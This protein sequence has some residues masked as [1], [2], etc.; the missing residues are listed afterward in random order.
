MNQSNYQ[1]DEMG[2]SQG[3]LMMKELRRPSEQA[4]EGRMVHSSSPDL[5]ETY[6][7]QNLKEQASNQLEPN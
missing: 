3:N 2:G 7:V 5:L 1:T 6:T 4:K